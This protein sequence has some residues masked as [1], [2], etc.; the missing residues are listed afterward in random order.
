MPWAAGGLQRIFSLSQS[1]VSTMA[2]SATSADFSILLATE[3]PTYMLGTAVTAPAVAWAQF[4]YETMVPIVLDLAATFIYGGGEDAASI[5]WV[6]LQESRD[7]FEALIE[8]R[9]KQ[10]C[11]ALRLMLGFNGGLP[12]AVYYNCLSGTDMHSAFFHLLV[13]I[14]SEMPLYHCMCV[15]SIG[16]PYPDFILSQCMSWVPA[17]R[18][19]LWQSILYQ[20]GQNMQ[21]VC[22]W[23][24][25]YI[26]NESKTIFDEWALDSQDAASALASL[27]Q[28]LIFPDAQT[29]GSCTQVESN[30]N[31]FTLLPIPSDHYQ[32]CGKTS[33]CQL[34]CQDAFTFF[35]YELANGPGSPSTQATA[36]AVSTE[37]PFFNPYQSTSSSLYYVDQR[38]VAMSTRDLASSRACST[39]PA[40]CVSIVKT[41]WT[42]SPQFKAISY[43]LPPAEALKAT[44][45]AA[46]LED[47]SFSSPSTVQE[48][49]RL[50]YCD[51]ALQPQE[52][53]VLLAYSSASISIDQAGFL[54]T[55]PASK[56]TTQQMYAVWYD[57]LNKFQQPQQ[58]ITHLIMDTSEISNLLMTPSVQKSV[59][60]GTAVSNVQVTQCTISNLV[61]LASSVRGKLIFFLS[62][63]FSVQG[64]YANNQAIARAGTV[65][66][67][68]KWQDPVFY[69]FEQT[70]STFQFFLACPR[71][72]V[73]CK[74]LSAAGCPLPSPGCRPGLDTVLDLGQVGSLL[75]VNSDIYLHIP[76]STN[77][78]ES[79]MPL[80]Y[81]Q[82]DPSGNSTVF[83]KVDPASLQYTANSNGHFY[84]S[85]FNSPSPSSGSKR[86]LDTNL[87]AWTRADVF[88]LNGLSTRQVRSPVI[89]T[90]SSAPV[91]WLQSMQGA[92]G[93]VQWF[94]EIR[95]VLSSVGFQLKTF[96]SQNVSTNAVMSSK[97]SPYS[98]AACSNARVRLACHALQDCM[99]SRSLPLLSACSFFCFHA[100][101]CA[102]A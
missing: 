86:S 19:G 92:A 56:V 4:T 66:G 51:F 82:I 68:L 101:A 37:S 35:E 26:H 36:F 32:I 45:Y 60:G 1:L 39:C 72:G 2:M 61:E 41:P 88:A 59:F 43:C 30:P 20:S 100:E 44:V 84:L 53:Y 17:S 9:L 80:Q 97:C 38:I 21:S 5:V 78:M 93:V 74:T 6:N 40:G 79:N 12:N 16:Q 15:K 11:S 87:G 28:D 69:P 7:N 58:A 89:E 63:T 73:Q 102:G 67:I 98:C 31:V 22:Q 14:S 65:N 42:T 46:G 54:F 99:I 18:K 47:W 90:A 27:L 75:H 48:G 24:G 50:T 49:A 85:A 34:R 96:H 76:S 64:Y 55:Q 3:N 23:Y 94:A 62:I 81:V 77:L 83:L 91:R 13:I 57:A 70:A 25:D 52:L 10:G 29:M 33:L 8:S 95:L 71:D